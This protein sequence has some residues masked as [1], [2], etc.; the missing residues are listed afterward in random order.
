MLTASTPLTSL[1]PVTSP[2]AR[3]TRARRSRSE[4]D[5]PLGSRRRLPVR[6]GAAAGRGLRHRH[7]SADRQRIAACR[8]RVFVHPHRRRGAL[9]A[10]ARQGGVLSHGLGRQRPA[11][12]TPRP[13]LLRRAVRPVAALRRRV[14]P[15][16]EAGQAADVGVAPELHRTVHP[17]DDGGREGVRGV[18][19]SNSDCRWTGR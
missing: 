10:D 7:P 1:D 18:C 14:C 5:A 13:E 17:P 9:P 3:K 11:D 15:A 6:S 19:G 12:R 8:P 2:S 4:V 16:R